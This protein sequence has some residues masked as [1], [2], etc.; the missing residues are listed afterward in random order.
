M[1][2]IYRIIRNR[3]TGLWMVASEIARSC[4]AAGMTLVAAAVMSTVAW[5][6]T[7]PSVVLSAGQ[8][9]N[10]YVAANG[11]TTVVNINAPSSQGLSHN[12]FTTYNVNP[13]GLVLNNTNANM[14]VTVQ[15]TLAGQVLTNNNLTALA[16]TILNEVVSTDR[17]VLNGFTEVLGQRAAVVVANP[18]GIT[19][20]GCGFI[21]TGLVTLST[22]SPVI[23]SGQLTGMTVTRGDILINGTGLNAQGVVNG[24]NDAVDLLNLLSRSIKIDGPLNAKALDIRTGAQAYTF[25]PSTLAVT[26]SSAVTGSGATPTWAIDATA[27]GGMYADT[28]RLVATEAG[29]GVR[30]HNDVA[31]NAGDFIL[32]AAGKIELRGKISSANDLSIS[33]S[34]T[35]T[36]NPSS[37]QITDA[38]LNMWNATLTATHNVNTTVGGQM[39]IEGGQIYAGN[40]AVLQLG[41]IKDRTTTSPQQGNNQRFAGRDFITSVTGLADIAQTN[42]KAG[43]DLGIT[44]GSITATA[45]NTQ[46][47]GGHDLSV[48]STSGNID[49]GQ[50]Q[51]Q[52]ANALTL[53]AAQDLMVGSGAG[54]GIQSSNGAMILTAGGA[55]TNAGSIQVK[56]QS[57]LTVGSMSNSGAIVLST[58]RTPTLNDSITSSGNVLNA[59]TG[60]IMSAGQVVFAL[61]S[62]GDLTNRG[63]LQSTGG[64][65]LTARNFIQDATGAKTLAG[66]SANAS[67]TDLASSINLSQDL[68]NQGLVQAGYGLTVNVRALKQTATSAALLGAMSNT[69]TMSLTLT[70]PYADGVSSSSGNM[71]TV[72]SGNDLSITAPSMTNDAT[73]LWGARNNLSLVASTGNLANYG[74]IYAGNDLTASAANG[75]IQN[76]IKYHLVQDQL[77]GNQNGQATRTSGANTAGYLYSYKQVLDSKGT[78]NA[79]RDVS[80]TADS[81]VNSSEINVGRNLTVS[82]REILNQVQGGDTRVWSGDDMASA[83]DSTASSAS[84]LDYHLVTND[85]SYYSFP[86][87][88]GRTEWIETWH[89]NQYF[90][91]NL[92]TQTGGTPVFK[93]LMKAQG[94]I[95]LQNFST[96]KNL[97]GVIEG[98]QVVISTTQGG[99]SFVNDALTLSQ[100]NYTR[101]S[102]HSVDYIALGPLTSGSSDVAPTTS[103]AQVAYTFWPSSSGLTDNVGASVRA[104]GAVSISGVSLQNLGPVLTGNATAP[105][106]PG[107]S[108]V[109]TTQA[110]AFPGLVLT[111]PTSP[112][113]YFVTNRDPASR[114]LVETNPLFSVAGSTLGS[115]YLMNQLSISP[116]LTQKR[117]G[118]ASYETYLVQQQLIAQTGSALLDGLTDV[119]AIFQ[120]LM[121]NAVAQS[122]ELGL[123]YGQAPSPEQLANLTD[124][125][126]WMVEVEV[127]GQKVLTPVVYLAPATTASVNQG[128]TIVASALTLDVTDMLNAG[129]TLSGSD[130]VNIAAKGDITNLSGTIKGGDVSLTSAEGSIKNE[131]YAQTTGGSGNMQTTLG[132]TASIQATGNL[133]LDAAKDIENRG[134]QMSAGGDA[135]LNAGN[136]ITFDTIE[137]KNSSST[138]INISE[139]MASG[140]QTTTTS[141]VTQVKSGLTVGGN[142]AA[143]AKN[144][145]TFAGTDV[146]VAGNAKVDAGNNLNIVAR[147][148]TVTTDTT[149]NLE[150]MGVGGGLYGTTE[151]TTN[152][153]SSRNVGSSF[154]V[155]G[156]AD[157]AAGQ[158]LTVQ[159]S[160]VNVGGDTS[161][162]ATD[163][164][165][166]AGKDVDRVTTTTKT[167]SFL[168]I[169]NVGDGEQSGSY[170][171]SGTQSGSGTESGAQAGAGGGEA[172]AS[173]YGSASASAGASA[174]AGASY[175]NSA[176]VTLMKSTTTTESSLSQR[177]VG[178]ALNLGGNVTI[179]AKNTV[180]L[181]GSELNAGGNVDLEA[182]NVELLA[183]QNIEQHSYSSTT[184]RLGLYASTENKAEASADASASADAKGEASASASKAGQSANAGVSAEANANAQ[185]NAKAEASSNNT[186]DVLRVDTKESESLK[187]TNT[188]SAIRSGGNMNIKVQETLRTVGSALEAE[189]DVNLAA[190]N[191]S[192]EAAQD[193]EYSK[194]STSTTRAG[195]YLDAGAGAE[196]KA[197]AGANA[198]ANASAGNQGLGASG[199]ASASAGANAEA[200]ANAQSKVGVG[201]QVKDTRST[202]EQ[203]S[204]T[205]VTSA[206]ISRSGSVSRTAEN[207]IRDVG[208]NIEAAQ[209]FNQSANRIESLAA[210]NSQFS[211]TTNEETTARIGVYA[212]AGAEA[213]A[214]AN[215]SAE[216]SGGVGTGSSS[217]EAKAEASASAKADSEAVVGTEMSLKRD[218]TTE[219]SRSTQAVTSNI[220]VGGNI[221]SQSKQA[222]VL[223]GTNM[224]AGGEVNLSAAELAILAARNTEETTSS[225]ESISANVSTK[226]GV[227]A[228][229]EAS[230]KAS[231][232]DGGSANAEA[233]AGIRVGVSASMGYSKDDSREAS[234]TAVTSNISGGK[235]NI[236]TTAKTTLEGTNL[237]AGD[238]G[239]NIV[240]DSLDFKAAQ[241]TNESSSSSLAVDASM[242]IQATAFA[243]ANIDAKADA[244]TTVANSSSSGTNAVVG[245]L[246]SGGGLNITTRGDTRLEGTQ[247]NATGDT[248]IAA[249]GNVSIEAA[250]NTF[251]ANSSSTSVSAGFDKDEGSANL[252]VDV[253]RSSESGSQAVVSNLST[254]GSLN[255]SAGKNMTLEGAN[256]EAG[257]DAQLAAG[258]NVTFKEARNEYSSN[259]LSVNV[260]LGS[261]SSDEENQLKSKQTKTESSKV[262][263]SFGVGLENSQSS[264]AVTGSIKAGNNLTVAAG[265]NATFV[266]TDL[267]AGNSAQVAA[268][269]DVNFQAAQSTSSGVSFGVGGSASSSTS[270]KRRLDDEDNKGDAE[271][272]KTDE[273][274]GN[275]NLGVNAATQQKGSNISAGAGGLQVSS[276]GNVNLQGTQIQ[277]DGSSDIS[278]AGKVTQ[279]AA[280][281][282]SVGFGIS[283][284]GSMKT[285]TK[286]GEVKDA[287]EVE[288]DKAKAAKE[289]EEKKS[290]NAAKADAKSD[291]K[292]DTKS[293]SNADDKDAA[294]AESEKKGDEKAE[295]DAPEVEKENTGKLGSLTLT[296]S[297][298]VAK[299]SIQAA[300][301][302]TVRSGVS[303]T[304]PIPG[305]SMTLRG[306]VQ[307]DGSLKALVPVPGNLPD[308]MQV[309]ATQPDGQP[310][311]DWVKFDAQTGSIAGQ[312]PAD[313]AGGLSIVVAVPQADGSVRKV[314]V[315]F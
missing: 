259:S 305:V 284:S 164:K 142:L 191:M 177:S 67:D 227:G 279:T 206:I 46:L 158:T 89:R 3:K 84:G 38:A 254:G 212:S 6:Q 230:A 224:Q 74:A 184:T 129:G 312:P 225:S 24:G 85:N 266:G 238:G 139:G 117:L 155:G 146:D 261:S 283:A 60:Q 243:G 82:A 165:V 270:E 137:D 163:V 100:E 213:E 141:T 201:I 160:T 208:T 170:A 241:D 133:S 99:A 248:N 176:G 35:N 21:N 128:A 264:E 228:G 210:E 18:N 140:V 5:A 166:L 219:T 81:V 15:S 168:Q 289:A 226:F 10:A 115:D 55:F 148:N 235:I 192:F 107:A 102:S 40:D 297:V 120:N 78:M 162:T 53:T 300:G 106:A 286:Q 294:A 130:S 136:N 8:S 122:G 202:T 92:S 12:T 119:A 214:K 186:V 209:D 179:N 61:G 52:T 48:T 131:T 20:T 256:V 308:G 7:T 36:A 277:T 138:T 42:W 250:R 41:S 43:H 105:S 260:G 79:G 257:S 111:L 44:A 258:G 171:N 70:A 175:S 274:S 251:Q 114:Y 150:G 304:S 296:A 200:S 211:R 180:T 172:G 194:E 147:E 310:L 204:S 234:T 123:T 242:K 167:T 216:A 178:S 87:L 58:E 299:T 222:T 86:N 16:S 195:L 205:A 293:N 127:E 51:V 28:I 113:G 144:D 132:Q 59:G 34:A 31:T 152:A 276:G 157:L 33:T 37:G 183:A 156:N 56:N 217:K 303:P 240:A 45:A 50:A 143:K 252:N 30:M 2:R 62:T 11:R 302:S 262:E 32:T 108:S 73:G 19:C 80:L 93:P 267:S 65:Q 134:A 23:S 291:A 88:H 232:E 181:Q 187:V 198:K 124:N 1:N 174:G 69:G 218:V 301:G 71:A 292:A 229:A 47:G 169:E 39:W 269:G 125:I 285:E 57:S 98:N 68:S 233:A 149:S 190:K 271:S 290:E 199:D 145:I 315:Q 298:D 288:A 118:D 126:V 272:T 282:S 249:G 90:A 239:I 101:T 83:S 275:F 173:A 245:S 273:A 309:K 17:S 110:S 153:F 77:L 223:Q 29:A 95:T 314:G 221:N 75:Q 280:V 237:N 247:I 25:D 231:S 94:T 287:E 159:G 207:T 103:K 135:A 311:P 116:N 96:A 76:Y 236:N 189:G 185:A 220:K 9:A 112:N 121:T 64:L 255:I 203:G 246:N 215:A 265:G 313:Y 161:I 109:S 278:A 182:K 244:S 193:I 54:Q 307:T 188:G 49:L 281:S 26:G 97:G 4:G 197:S 196:A 306:S 263:G 14:G 66:T 295:A 22:G 27:L 253:S 104:V 154:N 91:Y 72:F 268:A 13:S 151:T 63:Q